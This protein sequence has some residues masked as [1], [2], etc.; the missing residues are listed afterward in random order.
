MLRTICMLACS[1]MVTGADADEIS[2]AAEKTD[3]AL[4]IDAVGE[5]AIADVVVVFIVAG[6]A[7][8]AEAETGV[9]DANERE[10][11]QDTNEHEEALPGRCPPLSYMTE[12]GRL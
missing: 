4:A 5:A 11:R 2:D 12:A 8:A 3:A 10:D 1:S 7:A 9:D 6:A